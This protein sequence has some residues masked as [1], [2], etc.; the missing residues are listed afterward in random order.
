M[1]HVHLTPQTVA[2]FQSLFWK[3][4]EMLK[5]ISNHLCN[6]CP[7]KVRLSEVETGYSH[8]LLTC[9]IQI[10]FSS[11]E[12]AERSVRHPDCIWDVGGIF[13]LKQPGAQLLLWQMFHL[14]AAYIHRVSSQYIPRIEWHGCDVY[15]FL[16]D[17]VKSWKSNEIT[18]QL[19]KVK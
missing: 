1:W 14:G 18:F 9:K 3:F 2:G 15:D 10:R 7:H 8:Q 4:T 13:H 5:S 16:G 11:S 12:V 19:F 17:Y 6:I